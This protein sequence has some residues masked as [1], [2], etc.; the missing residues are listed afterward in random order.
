MTDDSIQAD[1]MLFEYATGAHPP[2]ASREERAAGHHH[3]LEE[4]DMQK[5]L[6]AA[7]V[8]IVGVV[9]IVVALVNNLFSVAPSFEDLTD[10]FRDTVMTDEAIAQAQQDIGALEAVNAEFPS[11]VEGL[12]PVF[13]TDAS[14]FQEVLASQ[15]PAVAT[16]VQSLPTIIEE[17]NGVIGLI[18]SQQSNFESADAL[19]T[20]SL[21]ATTLPW[22]IAGIGALGILVGAWMFVG[23]RT[24]AYVAVVL[25]IVVIA[26][27]LLLNLLGKSSDADAMNDAFRP[28][29]TQELVDQSGQA[30]Q[31]VGA[32]GGQLQSDVIPAVAQQMQMSAE[33]TLA[34]IGENYPATGAAL[35]ALPDAMGRFQVL[36]DTFD[37]QLGNYQDISDT[38]LN[39]ITWIVLIA[40]VAIFAFGIWGV[41][42]T[43]SEE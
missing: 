23:G 40:G 31:V 4:R 21:P 12:A 9:V 18:D 16:G 33:E 8:V 1:A 13:Q 41:L 10:G 27:T 20:S 15:F 19:P 29:Y 6:A 26:S 38:T 22:I 7:G 42:A 39:P 34:F 11:V 37:A 5:R 3:S 28:A 2:G 17:F 14:G 43:G 24:A 32:M 25:G 35:E 30:L 36:V